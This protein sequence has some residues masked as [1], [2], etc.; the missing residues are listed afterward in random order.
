MA[1]ISKI[2]DNY[3]ERKVKARSITNQTVLNSGI[4]QANWL[5]DYPW[6]QASTN[7]PIEALLHIVVSVL[8][9]TKTS[10]EGKLASGSFYSV[11]ER[12][13]STITY[14]QTAETPSASKIYIDVNDDNKVYIY[15]GS[16]Y[17]QI[18]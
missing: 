13:G 12:N 3:L 17:V 5:G 9:A 4:I 16:A 18:I 14:K 11:D 8:D 7:K 6:L 1:F 10:V 15:N 2:K